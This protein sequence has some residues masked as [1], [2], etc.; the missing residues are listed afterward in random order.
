M[1]AGAIVGIILPCFAALLGVTAIAYFFG[2]KRPDLPPSQN[3]ANNTIGVNS[4]TNIVN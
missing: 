1:S 4:S 2:K 3:I